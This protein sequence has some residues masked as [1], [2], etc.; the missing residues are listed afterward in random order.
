MINAE[1]RQLTVIVLWQHCIG[2]VLQLPAAAVPVA[3]GA[4][5]V[6]VVVTGGV[7]PRFPAGAGVAVARTE[8]AR[9]A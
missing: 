6:T 8:R 7:P 3:A 1:Q 2:P 9:T 4:E 5:T